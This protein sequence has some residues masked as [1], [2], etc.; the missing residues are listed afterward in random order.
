MRKDFVFTSHSVTDGHPDK[1]C[2]QI[3]D[4]IVDRF[5]QQD[6]QASVVAECAI[7]QAIVFLAVQFGANL[8]IDIPN[9][10]RNVINQVGYTGPTFS[11]RTCTAL[12]SIQEL[13][14][15]TQNRFDEDVLSDQELDRIKAR[16]N[17]NCFGFA[18]DQTPSLMPLPIHLAHKLSRRLSLARIKRTVPY[19]SPDGKTQVGVEYRDGWP[20][21]IQS[22]IIQY[23]P[24]EDYNLNLS[25]KRI[26]EEL[27]ETVVR[28]AFANE[29]IKP[30][31]KT[32][33]YIR[34]IYYGIGCGP[35]AHSGLTGRKTAVDT[36]G[37]YARQSGSAL[38]GK[39]PRRTDRIGVY[40]ARYAAKNIVAAGLA[41]E[42]EVQITYSIGLS[43]PASI[44]VETF[45]TGKVEEDKIAQAISRHFP[46]KPAEIIRKF[47]LRKLPREVKGG[48]YRKLA[49]YGQVGR[50]D[51]GVPWERGDMAD[52]LR[53]DLL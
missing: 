52:L 45:G 43:E 3:S 7:S 2:D 5:L 11:G 30:D 26:Q 18:C 46:L 41:R 31:E 53:D 38:S 12:T 22:I 25:K 37:E 13:P 47:R 6:P 44:Q 19:L 40:A 9:I 39:G 17:T 35:T 24:A 8:L 36:Y 51:I 23:C 28:P 20:H 48:F 33:I 16:N 14:Q 1:L 27:I 10:A 32:R 49:A 4:A 42:C 34:K 15:D 29:S 21:R 50:T